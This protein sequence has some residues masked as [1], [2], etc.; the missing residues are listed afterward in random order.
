MSTKTEN[1]VNV[2]H[3]S[4]VNPTIEQF[5]RQIL[6]LQKECQKLSSEI[7]AFKQEKQKEKKILPAPLFKKKKK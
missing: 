4:G 5:K 6:E 1:E 3:G 7:G 2:L